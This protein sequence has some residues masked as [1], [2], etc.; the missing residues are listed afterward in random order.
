MNIL[1]R[2]VVSVC[3]LVLFS[4]EANAQFSMGADG[5]STPGTSTVSVSATSVRMRATI[6]AVGSD[7]RRVLEQL[8]LMRGEAKEKLLKLKS[9]EASI[10]F[11]ET[12]LKVGKAGQQRQQEMMMMMEMMGEDSG[13]SPATNGPITAVCTLTA[14]WSIPESDNDA[15]ILFR[16]RIEEKVNELDVLG[17][18]KKP[19]LSDEQ[20]EQMEKTQQQ[21]SQYM[22]QTA[23]GSGAQYQFVGNITPEQ[24]ATAMKGAIEQA[25][26]S[27]LA[28]AKAAGIKRGKIVRLQPSPTSAAD[29]YYGMQQQTQ[30][31][32]GENEVIDDNPG[33]LQYK[34]TIQVTFA[35]E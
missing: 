13:P 3:A 8:R 27:A 2:Y 24:Q 18:T 19:D 25:S 33:T 23:E 11:S 16:R 12:S 10:E 35:I 31:P 15:M 20:A 5:I 21:M 32:T 17:S 6:K 29:M 28:L 14:D 1:T 7:A 30:F 4:P 9:T 26:R 34:S 22:G